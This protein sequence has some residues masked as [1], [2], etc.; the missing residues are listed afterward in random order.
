MQQPMELEQTE[1]QIPALA[2]LAVK[3][4]FERCI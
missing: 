2:E 1:E 3:R 4:A